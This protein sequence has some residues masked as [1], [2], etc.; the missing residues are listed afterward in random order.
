MRICQECG[1]PSARPLTRGRCPTCYARHLRALKTAGT[2]ESRYKQSRHTR[3]VKDRILEKTTPGWGGCIIWTGGTSDGYGVLSV[4]SF[5]RVAHRA[6]YEILI[7]P[8]P[9]GMELD[10][11]CH[12]ES[13]DCPGGRCIHRR[14]VNPHHLEPVTPVEN[15]MRGRSPVVANAFKTHCPQGHEYTDEN[16]YRKSNGQRLCRECRRAQHQAAYVKRPRE[17]RVRKELPERTHCRNGHLQDQATAFV[18]SAG[19]R[20]CRECRRESNRRSRTG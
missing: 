18:D 12:T 4:N 19:K 16:T 20:R 14:C 7:G 9:E 6:L 15:K 13:L 17:P 10:H 1:G 2:F 3:P 5:G 8:V 11:T